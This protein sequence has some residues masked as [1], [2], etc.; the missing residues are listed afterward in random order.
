MLQACHERLGRDIQSRWRYVLFAAFQLLFYVGLTPVTVWRIVVGLSLVPAFATLY[1]RLVLP[2]SKRYEEAQRVN[3]DV[4]YTK[5][6]D[7]SSGVTPS[8]SEEYVDESQLQ[9]KAHFGGK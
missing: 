3:S 7:V 9:K 6:K 5:E 1:Q 8:G 4:D 2:E